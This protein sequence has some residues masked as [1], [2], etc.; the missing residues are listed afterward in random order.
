MYKLFSTQNNSTL[1][2]SEQKKVNINSNHNLGYW[3]FYAQR[4]VAYAFADILQTMCVEQGKSYVVTP[5]QWGVMIFLYGSDGMTIGTISQKRGVDP[6]TVTGIVKRLE[7]NGLVERQNDREDRR[8]VKVK[9]TAEGET[10]TRIFNPVVEQFNHNMLL[11]LSEAEQ[12]TFLENLQ[13][14]IINLTNESE[15]TGDRFG[16]LPDS[17]KFK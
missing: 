1:N 5:P 7:Q 13:R 17:L 3:L 6:P 11:G 9:L 12:Q 14:I 10:M 4:C 2:I 15:G 8:V 16:L